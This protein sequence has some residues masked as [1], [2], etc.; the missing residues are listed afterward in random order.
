MM[1]ETELTTYNTDGTA[2]PIT[3][4][5]Q[6]LTICLEE[7]IRRFDEFVGLELKPAAPLYEADREAIFMMWLL[8]RY[9]E[10]VIVLARRDLILLP[11]A[12]L[13]A[14]TAFEV[15]TKI[16][17]LLDPGDPFEREVRWLAHLKTE[18]VFHRKMAK[19]MGKPTFSQADAIENF[20]ISIE[21]LLP[22]KYQLIKHLPNLR[23]MLSSIGEERKYTIYII[24]S[25]Y[26]HGT[27]SATSL[28]RQNL[29]DAVIVNDKTS[30]SHWKVPLS[31][32]YFGLAS[33]GCRIFQRWNHDP[34]RFL[35]NDLKAKIDK[36]FDEILGPNEWSF[37]VAS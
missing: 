28:Y 17:W 10:S 6:K 4:E 26:I 34:Y 24:L 9:V 27:H 21:K 35:T 29:G 20:R 33:A 23:D 18:E 31:A 2:I 11:G 3:S 19:E 8:I 1:G 30:P 32:C 16:L 7:L 37:P 25:Q 5:I 15:G 36:A 13:S 14:R 12:S 22:S